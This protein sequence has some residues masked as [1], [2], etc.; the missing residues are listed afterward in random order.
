MNRDE[1]LDALE[2]LRRVVR[3]TRDDTVLQNWG[4][5]WMVHACTNA[6]GFVA[7]GWLLDHGVRTPLPF[8][9][10]WSAVIAGNLLT[11][12]VLRRR[13]SGARSFVETQLWAIW[14]AFVAAVSVS[15]F[16]NYFMGLETLFLGPVIAVLAAFA[17][18][19]MGSLM[20]AHWYGVGALFLATALAMTVAPRFQFY[21]LGA[22]WGCTMFAFGWVLHRARRRRERS[23]EVRPQI[24]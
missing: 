11:V 22:V 7:T 19:S 3:E 13:R 5:I 18:A 15:A 23:P 12:A 17:Y 8:V 21:I 16:L 24:V 9:A 4:L 20:G 10:L 6:A 14:T 1:A 2:L